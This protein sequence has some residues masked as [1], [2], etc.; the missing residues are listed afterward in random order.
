MG[1]EMNLLGLLLQRLSPKRTF[2]KKR[3][4]YQ[5]MNQRTE[6]EVVKSARRFNYQGR[7]SAWKGKEKSEDGRIG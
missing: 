5:A 1:M 2:R 3:T 4:G 6:K 7:E